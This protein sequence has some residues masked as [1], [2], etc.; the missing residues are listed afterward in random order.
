MEFRKGMY[1]LPQAGIL[2]NKLLEKRLA[3]HG[4]YK[5]PHTPGLFKHKSRPVWF[6][7]AVDN[8]GIKYIGK[9][10]LQHLYDALRTE[11]Y[12][13]VEDRVGNLYCGINLSWHC[14]KGYFDLSMPKYVMKQLACYAHPA[15][16]IPQ[17]CPFSPNPI[18]YGK[19]N[20]ATTPADDSPLLDNAGKKRIQQIVGRL[21]Y[22]A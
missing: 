19:D 10:N 22:Y 17:H 9:D 1:G 11:S 7:L 20:Q 8:F 2:A 15:P 5:Q 21:L 14:E 12:N 4:Y 18:T 13:I 3:I 16:V 6:N